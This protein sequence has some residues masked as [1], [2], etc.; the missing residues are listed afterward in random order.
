MVISNLN[1]FHASRRSEKKNASYKKIIKL[2]ETIIIIF[3]VMCTFIWDF[4]VALK[5]YFLKTGM[6]V[7]ISEQEPI[8]NG[9]KKHPELGINKYSTKQW[10]WKNMTILNLM[11]DLFYAI[12]SSH[13]Y[14]F[15]IV[16]YSDIY[17][18]SCTLQYS[19]PYYAVTLHYTAPQCI[20]HSVISNFLHA[21]RR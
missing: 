12:P 7:S 15:W 11:K 14:A 19:F 8:F 20:T 3:S 4:T 2:I 1:F 6:F 10:L 17:K 18:V 9:I 5:A 21:S 13:Y 16:C